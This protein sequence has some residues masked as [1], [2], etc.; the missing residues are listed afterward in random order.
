MSF[1]D[2]FGICLKF[3][4][5][6]LKSTQAEIKKK[7]TRWNTNREN[8]WK[9]YLELTTDNKKLEE[10]ASSD[11]K[12]PEIVMNSIDK[13]MNSVKFIAFG[14]VK[15]REREIRK[16]NLEKLIAQ[17]D[18]LLKNSTN[19]SVGTPNIDELDE[20]ICKELQIKQKEEVEKELSNL[21][22]VKKRKGK[23]AAIFSLKEKIVGKKKE[24]EEQ[25]AVIDPVTNEI[26]CDPAEIIKVCADYCQNLLTNDKPKEDFI[27]DLNWKRR[28]HEVRMNEV[29]ENDIELSEEMFQEAFKLVK[30]REERNTI[31]LQTEVIH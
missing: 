30:K 13:E 1:P 15:V 25:C 23:S 12:D 5:I 9:S 17:K 27:D 10:I 28:V 2:H 4:G 24:P 3:K 16:G 7:Y 8:G 14:K 29:I 21:Y 6:P 26:V 22:N 18:I 20:E 19:N 31:S 11:T